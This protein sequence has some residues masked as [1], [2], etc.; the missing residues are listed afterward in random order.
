MCCQY[1]EDTV[2]QDTVIKFFKK[3][4][5][6]VKILNILF[7]E[8][9]DDTVFRQVTEH[10]KKEQSDLGLLSAQVC[11]SQYLFFFFLVLRPVKISH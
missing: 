8:D 5:N 6:Y 3:L 11:L 10:I 4:K 7:G 1:A 2:C 9:T